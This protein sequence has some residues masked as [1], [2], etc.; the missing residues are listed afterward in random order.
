VENLRQF[1]MFEAEQKLIAHQI[2][3]FGNLSKRKQKFG[4]QHKTCYLYKSP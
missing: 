1:L 3:R 4:Y 2:L